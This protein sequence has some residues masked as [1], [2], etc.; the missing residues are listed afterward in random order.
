MRKLKPRK[1][2]VLRLSFLSMDL[3]GHSQPNGSPVT[4]GKGIVGQ[5]KMI[6]K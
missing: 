4:Y 2:V 6:K 1:Y 5:Q 3:K